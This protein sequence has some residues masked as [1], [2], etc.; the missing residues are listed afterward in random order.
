M[1]TYINAFNLFVDD[2]K[3]HLV[4][5]LGQ[6]SP[7]MD[8]D[9]ITEEIDTISSNILDSETALELANS[10]IELIAANNNEK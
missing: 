10:I 4:L 2:D 7:Q 5:V 3:R 9:N 1:L 6:N 8:G